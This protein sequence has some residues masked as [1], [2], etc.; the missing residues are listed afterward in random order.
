MARSL[1]ARMRTHK[2]FEDKLQLGRLVVIYREGFN[3]VF[4]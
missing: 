4:T 1:S 2:C 3:S